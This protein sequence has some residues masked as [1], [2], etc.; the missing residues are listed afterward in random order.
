MTLNC[1][2]AINFSTFLLFAVI[3]YDSPFSHVAKLNIKRISL[4]H[5]GKYTCVGQKF[6]GSEKH[7]S[8]YIVVEGR[9]F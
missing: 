3:Y 6:N 5:T 1:L 9:V 8:K 7:Q 4:N 2:F